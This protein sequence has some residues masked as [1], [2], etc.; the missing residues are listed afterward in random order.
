MERDVR[1]VLEAAI[2]TAMFAHSGQRD[3]G[4]N[5]YI[6][7]P[8]RVMSR[9]TGI[10]HQVVALLHDVIEDGDLSVNQIAED[11]GWTVADAVAALT[12]RE[13]ETYEAFIER[14][15]RNPIARVVKLA[16]LADNMDL[17]RLNREP[18]EADMKRLT[19]YRLATLALHAQAALKTKETDHA[20]R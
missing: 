10:D 19:K 17:S 3:K 7:H 12:R 11:F 20:P 6:L 5:P 15:G 8:L 9:V 1:E 14:C 18:T 16:D 13:S 2:N 4:G